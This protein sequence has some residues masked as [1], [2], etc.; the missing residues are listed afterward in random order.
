MRSTALQADP[1]ESEENR[2]GTTSFYNPRTKKVK[3]NYIMKG[4]SSQKGFP[5]SSG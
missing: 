2:P 1:R 5:F 4:Y 3:G